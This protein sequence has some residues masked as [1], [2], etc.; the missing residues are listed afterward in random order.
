MK[1]SCEHHAGSQARWQSMP[2]QLPPCCLAVGAPSRCT[3]CNMCSAAL[4]FGGC[5]A[6]SLSLDSPSSNC[7]AAHKARTQVGRVKCFVAVHVCQRHH[8]AAAGGLRHPPAERAGRD[9]RR[10][11]HAVA[12]QACRTA[13]AGNQRQLHPAGWA[14][15]ASQPCQ[16]AHPKPIFSPAPAPGPLRQRT[17]GRPW[18]RGGTRWRPPPQST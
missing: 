18:A 2:L 14:S 5:T 13:Q 1:R 9:R 11:G 6:L 17:A 7:P 16:P 12:R 10:S 3:A 15:K 8:D 4:P